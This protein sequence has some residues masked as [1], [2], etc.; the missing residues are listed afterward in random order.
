[1]L[2]MAEEK[3]KIGGDFLSK[4][5]TTP[6]KDQMFGKCRVSRS[7]STAGS[8]QAGRMECGVMDKSGVGKVRGW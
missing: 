1:M 5:N 2:H 3:T 4:A 6:S 8:F 7:E